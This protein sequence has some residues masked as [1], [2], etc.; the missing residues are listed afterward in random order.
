M[1]LT[2]AS[3]FLSILMDSAFGLTLLYY[4]ISFQLLSKQFTAPNYNKSELF[5]LLYF[6]NHK[7]I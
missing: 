4:Q 6:L 5:V 1:D 2:Y 3:H 7:D